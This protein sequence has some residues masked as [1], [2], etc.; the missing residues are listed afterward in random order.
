[1]PYSR[2]ERPGGRSGDR[3][4]PWS[5]D[6]EAGAAVTALELLRLKDTLVP[7]SLAVLSPYRQQVRLLRQKMERQIDGSLV[8]IKSFTPAVDVNE[9]CGT[10]DSFQGGEAD[11]VLISLVRNNPHSTPAKALGFLRDNR[12]MNVLLSRAKWRLILIGSLRFY[13]RIVE[14]AANIPD[15]H[16][17]FLA[18]FIESLERAVA[19]GEGCIVPLAR[20]RGDGP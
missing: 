18:K 11:V 14:L 5:N 15:Q 16:V 20:L 8:H 19:A 9:F 7:P 3:P 2:E 1:M 17:G 6:D 13:K 12:R 10:V 4:P